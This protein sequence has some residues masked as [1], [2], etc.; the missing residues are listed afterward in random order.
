VEV[1]DNAPVDLKAIKALADLAR[2]AI[3]DRPFGTAR[4]MLDM[5][6]S[7]NP[8]AHLQPA[9]GDLSCRVD[10]KGRSV[11]ASGGLRGAPAWGSARRHRHK[12]AKV[13]KQIDDKSAKD[14]QKQIDDLERKVKGKQATRS[15]FDKLR[16]GVASLL[17]KQARAVNPGSAPKP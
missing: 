9:A 15:A 13:Q 7:E 2:D 6:R 8:R 5:L 17:K 3:K 4:T 12:S 10:E 11:H 14:F 1:A 16:D